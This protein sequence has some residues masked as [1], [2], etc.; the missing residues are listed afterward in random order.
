MKLINTALLATTLL[1]ANVF[2]AQFVPT[3]GNYEQR[4]ATQTFQTEAVQSKQE[5]YQLSLQQLRKLNESSSL[6]LSKILRLGVFSHINRRTIHLNN[7]GYIAVEEFMNA[8]G[9]LFYKG[10]INVSYHYAELESND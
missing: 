8:E 9:Q 10:Q 6:E 5:A 7:N 3:P 4:F 2:A 1:S